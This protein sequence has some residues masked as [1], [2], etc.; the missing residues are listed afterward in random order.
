LL[1]AGAAA[2]RCNQP[3]KP[4]FSVTARDRKSPGRFE[5]AAQRFDNSQREPEPFGNSSEEHEHLGRGVE[6][7]STRAAM[8][9]RRATRAVRRAATVASAS[10]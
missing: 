4:L 9:W 6:S 1:S 8:V 5:L 7:S 10:V 2:S 3:A